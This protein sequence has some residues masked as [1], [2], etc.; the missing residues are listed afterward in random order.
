MDNYF[1]LKKLLYKKQE[2]FIAAEIITNDINEAPIEQI[3]NLLEKRGEVLEQVNLID[4]QIKAIVADDEVLRGVLNCT[5]EM[6]T[7]QGELKELF[8][9]SL[10]AKA[11]VNRIIK[12]EDTIRLRIE[13]ERDS[14]LTKIETINS[15]SN[16]IAE[17]YKRSVKTGF[18]Q[19][20]LNGRNK[21]I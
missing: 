15:S 5:C 19:G 2:L 1:E 17:S 8:E 9:E 6:S 10:R 21:T 7:L 13:N 3:T 16:S 20:F 14:L 18:S 11:I 4:N 12:N